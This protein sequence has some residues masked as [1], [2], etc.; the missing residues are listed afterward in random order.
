LEVA[1]EAEGGVGALGVAQAAR[2]RVSA[3]A[4]NSLHMLMFLSPLFLRSLTLRGAARDATVAS[5]ASVK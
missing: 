3:K 2:R 1:V 4:A 5:A